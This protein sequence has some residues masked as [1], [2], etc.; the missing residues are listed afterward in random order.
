MSSSPLVPR[1][2]PA[3]DRGAIGGARRPVSYFLSPRSHAMPDLARPASPLV[4]PPALMTD[5][6]AEPGD[7]ARHFAA[8]FTFETDCW[9]VH[10]ALRRDARGFVVLYVRAP[11]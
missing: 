3:H 10:D 9:D 4:T 7:A 11:A 5:P 8:Q 1:G 2:L 6:V